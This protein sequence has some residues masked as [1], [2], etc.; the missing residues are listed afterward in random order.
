MKRTLTIPNLT[1]PG[2]TCGHC[3]EALIDQLTHLNGV[4]SIE[5]DFHE[6]TLTITY[7]PSLT[8]EGLV[9]QIQSQNYEVSNDENIKTKN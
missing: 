1:C 6:K 8:I 3:A 9:E 5:A 7:Q 2:C 4:A